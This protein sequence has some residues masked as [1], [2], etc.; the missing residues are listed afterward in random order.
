MNHTAPARSETKR[1]TLEPSTLQETCG[2]LDGD[3]DQSTT[4]FSGFAGLL[5]TLLVIAVLCILCNWNKRKKRPVPYLRVTVMPSLTLP[6]CRQRSKNIYDFLPRRQEEPGRHQSRSIRIFSTERL[7]S[8]NSDSPTPEHVLSRA[9]NALQVHAVHT[10]A[11]GYAVGVY[12]NTMVPQMC[13]TFTPSAPYVNVRASRDDLSISS[14]DSRD[15]VNVPRAEEI[16]ENLASNSPRNLSV[17]PSTQELDFTEK[18]DVGCGDTSDCTRFWS[19]GTESSNEL[20]DEESSS[21]TSNDYV[22]VS[23]LDLG[24]A[25]REKPWTTFQCCRDYENVPPADVNGSQQQAE[26]EATSLNTDHVKGRTDALGTHTQPVMQSGSF[27]VLGDHMAF[28]PLAQSGN[29]QMKHGEETP[30]EDD[31]DYENVLAAKL[32]D[33][34]S[35]Q[36]SGTQLLPDELRPSDPAGK[37][38]GMVYPAGSTAT[39]ESSDDP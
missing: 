9:G 12:D 18:R 1:M 8:R 14:E 25:Q 20:S 11:M 16:A 13:G 31:S 23:E 6:Q 17:L 7:L 10:C 32:G 21:Q 34:D 28:Q 22:N 3:K 39:T 4:I 19:P 5:A 2:S 35:E 30:S 15:Y 38:H 37:L 27:L 33:K 24:A 26:E 36:G 29:S